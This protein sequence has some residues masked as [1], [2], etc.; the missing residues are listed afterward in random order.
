MADVA[1]FTSDFENV[2]SFGQVNLGHVPK[3]WR[4]PL[5]SSNDP[6]EKACEVNGEFTSQMLGTIGI[7]ANY[8]RGIEFEEQAL[9]AF[10]LEKNTRRIKGRALNGERVTTIPDALSG[11]LWEFKN[12][13]YAYYSRQLQAQISIAKKLGRP[14]NLVVNPR[15]TVSQPLRRAVEETGG[16]VHG[17]KPVS[18]KMLP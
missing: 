13:R 3:G 2:G 16:R 9:G 17:F 5:R 10:G 1:D 15:T 8:R 12:V 7:A 6:L 11:G 4:Q 18:G 14:F